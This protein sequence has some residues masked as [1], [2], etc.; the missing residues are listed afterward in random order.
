[1]TIFN[2]SHS[3]Q[4]YWKRT[5]LRNLI[6]LTSKSETEDLYLMLTED[7]MALFHG[8]GWLLRCPRMQKGNQLY[9]ITMLQR[10]IM[11]T[12]SSTPS[13]YVE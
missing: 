2:P 4:R 9:L 5:G 3:L 11:S 6:S 10:L 8:I 12:N 1:M 7:G 13:G